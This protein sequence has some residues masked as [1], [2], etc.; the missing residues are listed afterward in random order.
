MSLGLKICEECHVVY[1]EHEQFVI[2]PH[3]WRL[4]VR[5]SR[6]QHIKVLFHK[7]WSRDVDTKAYNKEDWMELQ[8][9]LQTRGIEV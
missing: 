8:R 7:L 2:C 5:E 4:A 1:C 9:L 6:D 3:D